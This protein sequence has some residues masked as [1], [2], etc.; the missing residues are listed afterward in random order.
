[1]NAERLPCFLIVS[2]S[3]ASALAFLLVV[4]KA[5][6]SWSIHQ[7]PVDA[8]SALDGE[9]GTSDEL[10]SFG[11]LATPSI[12]AQF[13]VSDNKA[14]LPSTV[15]VSSGETTAFKGG[16]KRG[17][18][19]LDATSQCDHHHS[20]SCRQKLQRGSP[21]LH[22]AEEDAAEGWST[23]RSSLSSLSLVWGTGIENMMFQAR[24]NVKIQAKPLFKTMTTEIHFTLLQL[25][26]ANTQQKS[27]HA[28]GIASRVTMRPLE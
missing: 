25:F 8:P 18:R 13:K 27:T 14:S 11:F 7:D 4:S 2:K 16:S 20:F 6:S 1:M 26:P 23:L 22:V 28:G 3:S 21:A 15:G 5:F 19:K 12:N 17:A 9:L 10:S 24:R